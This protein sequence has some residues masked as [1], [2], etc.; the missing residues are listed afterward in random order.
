M[1]ASSDSLAVISDFY[2]PRFPEPLRDCTVISLLKQKDETTVYLVEKD[3]KPFVLKHCSGICADL[4]KNEYDILMSFKNDFMPKAEAF[5][6][7][8]GESWLLREY[9]EG[10]SLFELIKHDGVLSETRAVDIISRLCAVLGELHTNPVK[11]VHRDIKPQN[12]IIDDTG[13]L[14]VIDM[15][16]ARKIKPDA[17]KDTICAGTEDI[18]APEQFGYAQT[19]ARTDIYALGMLLLFLLRGD[20]DKNTVDSLHI[21]KDIK[22]VIRKCLSFAPS[23]RYQSVKALNKALS[24]AMLINSVTVNNILNLTLYA[25]IFILG[26]A[27][28]FFIRGEQANPKNETENDFNE[29]ITEASENIADPV[30][31]KESLIERAVREA[32]NLD[33]E[34]KIYLRDMARITE[35]CI[36]GNTVCASGD[37]GSGDDYTEITPDSGYYDLLIKTA[38]DLESCVNLRQLTLRMQRISDISPLTG[39]PL[40]YLD[41]SNN[42]QLEDFTPLAQCKRLYWLDIS[43]TAVTDLSFVENLHELNTLWIMGNR[44][45]YSF[46]GLRG[47]TVE[48]LNST[49]VGARNIEPLLTLPLKSFCLDSLTDDDIEQLC[50]IKTLSDFCS[51]GNTAVTDLTLFTHLPMLDTLTLYNCYIESLDGAVDLKKLNHLNLVLSDVN[52]IAPIFDI[53]RLEEI[54]VNASLAD[55]IYEISPEPDFSVNINEY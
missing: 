21:S 25:A 1:T 15:G 7:E 10:R 52:Y 11:I 12:I 39:L 47:S 20:F 40:A 45:L 36:V 5:Y 41:L 29:L 23:G 34:Q 43:N 16:T 42:K 26:I 27:I 8:N 55:K 30:V 38:E 4:L 19:D 49:N 44:Q 46:E 13:K 2:S 54:T 17:E 3:G 22:R 53:P 14:T 51:M 37:K 48:H 35:L 32:L 28:G 31:F 6:S 50:S 24:K 33:G 18:A 9:V